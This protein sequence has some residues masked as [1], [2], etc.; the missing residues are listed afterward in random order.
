[1]SINYEEK[2]EMFNKLEEEKQEYQKLMKKN[3]SKMASIKVSVD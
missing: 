2:I 1:M 3:V